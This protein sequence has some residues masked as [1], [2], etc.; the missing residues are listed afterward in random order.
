MNDTQ[1]Q[2]NAFDERI[3]NIE[4]HVET[5]ADNVLALKDTLQQV[6]DALVLDQPES[7]DK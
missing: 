3:T 1:A 7:D 2:L 5:L 4:T 6:A